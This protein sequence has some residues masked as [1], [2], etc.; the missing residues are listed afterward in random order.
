MQTA[1]YITWFIFPTF[2]FLLALWAKLEQFSGQ[3]KRHNPA[4]LLKQGLFVLV[5][6]LLCIGIDKTLLPFVAD[7][8]DPVMIPLGFYQALLLPVVLLVS[9]KLVG[10]SKSILISSK[11]GINRTK[12]KQRPPRRRP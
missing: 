11:N 12:Q 10:G 1:L 7:L 4:D 3:Q 5:C 8:I 9:A 2:F 6:V